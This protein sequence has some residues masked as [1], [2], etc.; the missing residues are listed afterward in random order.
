LI[1]QEPESRIDLDL[2]ELNEI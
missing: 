1:R 2:N